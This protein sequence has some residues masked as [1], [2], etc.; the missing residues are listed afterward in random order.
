M[1]VVACFI[2]LS[3][4]I[5]VATI[6]IAA[7]RPSALSVHQVRERFLVNCEFARQHNIEHWSGRA[8][9]KERRAYRRRQRRR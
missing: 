2:L 4:V 7:S 1:I 9:E 6:V 8:T 5:I 3:P